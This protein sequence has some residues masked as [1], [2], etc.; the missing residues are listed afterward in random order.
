MPIN[1]Y[2]DEAVQGNGPG[3]QSAEPTRAHREGKQQG[4][5]SVPGKS[6][7]YATKA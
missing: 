3:T 5:A 6:D 1:S 7:S 2:I 4:L